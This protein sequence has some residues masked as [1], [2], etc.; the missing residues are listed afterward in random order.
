MA[1][2]GGG[3]CRGKILGGREYVFGEKIGGNEEMDQGV[4]VDIRNYYCYYFKVRRGPKPHQTWV[5]R[6]T[7]KDC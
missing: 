7:T 1:D 6:G 5:D 2:S 4:R 3:R